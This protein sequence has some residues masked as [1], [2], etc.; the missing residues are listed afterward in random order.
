MKKLIEKDNVIQI[1]KKKLNDCNILPAA[2]SGFS[3]FQSVNNDI[4]E[5]I[6][7]ACERIEKPGKFKPDRVGICLCEQCVPTN[8]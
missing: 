5:S 8:K 2:I 6:N 1:V 4:L 7:K 3:V